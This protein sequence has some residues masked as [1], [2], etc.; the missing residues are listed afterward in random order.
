MKENEKLFLDVINLKIYYI[1]Y[2]KNKLN[3]KGYIGQSIYPEKRFEEHCYSNYPIGR[4]IK[5]HKKENFEIIILK[6]TFFKNEANELEKYYIKKYN[7]FINTG[8]GYN[9]HEGGTGGNTL[10]GATIEKKIEWKNNV[11]KAKKEAMIKAKVTINNKSQEE[12]DR[13]KTK[14]KMAHLNKS[15][16]EK[17][18]IK[19]KLKMAHLNKSQEEKDQIKIK[20]KIAHLNKSQEEKDQIKIKISIAKKGKPNLKLKGRKIGPNLIH[21]ERMR[22]RIPYNKTIINEN[23]KNFIIEKINLKISIEKIKDMFN[24]KFNRCIKV[25]AFRNYIKTI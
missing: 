11:N 8:Y 12:K 19:I 3:N 1:Y 6:D 25:G 5:K 14:I 24:E 21:S 20:L 18:Q 17:D 2:I 15:Q 22:G 23:E 4:A 10:A 7:T 16:E 9:I 13:I